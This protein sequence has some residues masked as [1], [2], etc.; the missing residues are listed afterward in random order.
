MKRSYAIAGTAASIVLLIFLFG[1]DGISL[2]VHA[3]SGVFGTRVHFM[4]EGWRA[5]DIPV[6][7]TDFRVLFKR[8]SG[9][10]DRIKV[11]RIAAGRII[12]L[13]EYLHDE[14][15]VLAQRHDETNGLLAEAVDPA[16]FT[17]LV[18]LMQKGQ[19][20]SDQL[21]WLLG[22]DDERASIKA[23]LPVIEACGS[24]DHRKDRI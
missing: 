23:A 19:G 12:L 15:R 17:R 22:S 3:A 11:E 7:R 20:S 6:D 24:G 5:L 14:A 4:Q 21:E 1:F 10:N 18:P 13:C 16:P 9:D 2:A 8:E